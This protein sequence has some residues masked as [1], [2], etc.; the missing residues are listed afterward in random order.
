MITGQVTDASIPAALAD[1]HMNVLDESGMYITNTNTDAQGVYYFSGLAD[2]NYKVIA[3]DVPPG[4]QGELYGGD[5]CH[6]WSCDTS[7]AGTVI[8]ITGGALAG[9]KDIDLD[10]AGTRLF[11]TVTRS[12]TDAPVSS[13]HA[14]LGIDLF[15]ESG[16]HMGGSEHKLSRSVPD[17]VARRG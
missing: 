3:I 9:G 1:V 7:T 16:E 11:G 4:Y 12:D 15:N 6:D 2:G 8:T 17:R 14:H 5:H 13:L 10:Y